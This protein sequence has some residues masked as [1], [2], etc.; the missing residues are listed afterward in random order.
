MP[1]TSGN[2]QIK[3]RKGDKQHTTITYNFKGNKVQTDG[4]KKKGN[5][6]LYVLNVSIYL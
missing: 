2:W 6:I 4:I 5:L 1:K 3:I